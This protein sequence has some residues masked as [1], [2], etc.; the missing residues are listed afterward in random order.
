MPQ[1]SGFAWNHQQR[2]ATGNGSDLPTYA[3][4][5]LI[6]MT[7]A[8]VRGGSADRARSLPV[9]ERAQK[10]RQTGLSRF[11]GAMYVARLFGR[12]LYEA[13]DASFVS[14]GPGPMILVVAL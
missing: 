6:A 1:I 14:R 8:H 4:G 3:T 13:A 5:I 12:L 11:P 9:A 7:G 10:V 2:T